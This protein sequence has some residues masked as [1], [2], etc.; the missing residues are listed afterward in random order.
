MT[1]NLKRVLTF[2][3]LRHVLYLSLFVGALV[4]ALGAI[5]SSSRVVAQ[6]ADGSTFPDDRGFGQVDTSPAV[7]TSPAGPCPPPARCWLAVSWSEDFDSVIPPVLPPNWV[8]TNTQGPPPL[9]VTSDSGVPVPPAATLPNAAFI[10]DPGVVSDKLLDATPIFPAD[11]PDGIAGGLLT[12]VQTFNLEA[13]DVDPDVGFDGGVLEISYDNGNT[14]QDILDAGGYFVEGG[15]NRTISM[16]RGSPIAGR[17][18]WSGDSGGLIETQVEVNI[19]LGGA[20]LRWRMAS[21]ISGSNEGWRIDS[22]DFAGCVPL[23]CETPT[24]TPPVTPT[25]SITPTP[26]PTA[27]PRATPRLRPTPHPRPSP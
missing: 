5:C 27:T 26:S 25:P 13:S 17:R 15:Y 19:P 7:P 9:W 22:V 2:N 10:D 20:K 6:R 24:P 14:F 11:A 23:P 18:A 12:F 4:A 21:D 8:A 16:D 1:S 3:R